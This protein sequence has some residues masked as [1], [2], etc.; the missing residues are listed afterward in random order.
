MFQMMT[1]AERYS[2]IAPTKRASGWV[3]LLI[4]SSVIASAQE[5]RG[6]L[7]KAGI[8]IES[9]A[10]AELTG[11][12]API[13]RQITASHHDTAPTRVEYAERERHLRVKQ[14]GT[15]Y[16]PID[17]WIYAAFDRLQALGYAR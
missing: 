4:I 17:S 7:S 5:V 12:L 16:V 8:E 2:C 3:A 13:R 11:R 14:T 6:E 10:V 1:L 15:T 9:S